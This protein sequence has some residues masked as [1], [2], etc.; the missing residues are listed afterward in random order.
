MYKSNSHNQY[1][2]NP[3]ICNNWIN[4]KILLLNNFKDCLNI[5][6]RCFRESRFLFVP[7]LFKYYSGNRRLPPYYLVKIINK[8]RERILPVVMPNEV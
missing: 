8:K 4:I 5:K 1:K 7:K 2:L 6:I 3:I